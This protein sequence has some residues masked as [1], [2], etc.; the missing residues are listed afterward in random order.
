MQE[1]DLLVHT[2]RHEAGPMAVLE[3]AVAGVPA[4]GTDVG[5]VNEWAPDA[6]VAV[7]V[8][9]ACALADAVASLLDDEPRRLAIAR[10]A[11]A[12]ATGIDADFTATSFERLYD[13]MLG[14]RAR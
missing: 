1:S 3:A 13:E 8:G 2:S 5:H 6:A 7:P 4:V 11:Q 10:E 14:A 9:D 12:R